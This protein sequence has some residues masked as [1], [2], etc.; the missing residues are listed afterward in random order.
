MALYFNNQ[1]VVANINKIPYHQALHKIINKVSLI[2]LDNLLLQDIN[3]V[4]LLS[5]AD[6][7][8]YIISLDQKIILDSNGTY[9]F[10]KEE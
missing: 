2:S 6:L 10:S 9:L 1:R 8:N 5:T 7:T 3:G 4:Y